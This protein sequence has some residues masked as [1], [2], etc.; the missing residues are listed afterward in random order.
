MSY[1]LAEESDG[2]IVALMG[3]CQDEGPFIAHLKA[4][5]RDDPE[6]YSHDLDIF[7]FDAPNGEPGAFLTLWLEGS[8]PIPNW[9]WGDNRRFFHY[10][11]LRFGPGSDYSGEYYFVP[12][13]LTQ[14]AP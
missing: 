8:R 6:K 5:C 7:R 2:S 9:T 12:D 14:E 1:Y 11:I 3:P 4:I 13:V 10:G